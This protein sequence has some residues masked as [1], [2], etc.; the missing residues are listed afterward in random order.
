MGDGK[1]LNPGKK[2]TC[3]FKVNF[4]AVG[5][6]IPLIVLSLKQKCSSPA[7]NPFLTWQMSTHEDVHF[8]QEYAHM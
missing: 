8:W 4:S 1:G 3:T 2:Y 7:N 5:W 6:D